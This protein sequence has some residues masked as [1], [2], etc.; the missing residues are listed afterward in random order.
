[1]GPEILAQAITWAV[2]PSVVAGIGIVGAAFAAIVAYR[3]ARPEATAIIVDAAKDIVVLQKG[4]L[5]R[6]QQSLEAAHRRIRELERENSTLRGK[7]EVDEERI[8][9]LERRLDA[10]DKG[11]PR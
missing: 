5:Q 3:K 11:S 1:M 9:E 6:L 7:V 2:L 8:I 10:L 4:E